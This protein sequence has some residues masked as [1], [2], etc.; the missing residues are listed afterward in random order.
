MSGGLQRSIRRKN[1]ALYPHKGQKTL[2]S[3]R[4]IVRKAEKKHK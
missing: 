1:P 2:F 3:I 4:H